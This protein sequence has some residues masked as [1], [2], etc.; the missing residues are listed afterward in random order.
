MDWI[1]Q[2]AQLRP[3]PII[4]LTMRFYPHSLKDKRAG[5]W[6]WQTS[7]EHLVI[8]PTNHQV[9]AARL[10]SSTLHSRHKSNKQCPPPLKIYLKMLNI[11]FFNF[12]H[13]TSR[14]FIHVDIRYIFL[15]VLLLFLVC[16]AFYLFLSPYGVHHLFN[17]MLAMSCTYMEKIKKLDLFWYMYTTTGI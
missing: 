12:T 13:F 8:V 9:Q 5:I 10:D 11:L 16:I 3:F 14:L 1:R 7:Y 6:P 4:T 17:L 2:F 15:L